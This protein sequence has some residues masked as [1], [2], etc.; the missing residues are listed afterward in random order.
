MALRNMVTCVYT[1]DEGKS[2]LRRLDA[3]YQALNDGATPPNLLLGAAIATTAQLGTLGNTSRDIS[4]R[5]VL[6]AT[7]DGAFKARLPVFTLARYAAINVGD[8]GYT[9]FDGQGVT[10][11]GIVYGK[12][13]ER[14]KHK[15]DIS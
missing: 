7:S 15:R 10:H 9:F 1:S 11:A 14:S 5:S 12:E 6:V 8:G 3:R 13:G 4:P 2:E